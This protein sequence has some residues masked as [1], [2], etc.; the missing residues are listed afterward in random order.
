MKRGGSMFGHGKQVAGEI[1]DRNGGSMRGP[2]GM[3]VTLKNSIVRWC[4][5]KAM[6]SRMKAPW[7]FKM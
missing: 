3:D 4:I 7:S 6:L 2:W 1:G 5:V